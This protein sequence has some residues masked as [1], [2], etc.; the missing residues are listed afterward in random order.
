MLAGRPILLDRIDVH[1]SW[2]S[3]KVL[4]LIGHLPETVE[5]GLIVRDNKGIPTGVTYPGI[6]DYH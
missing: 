3:S 6:I 4:D 5:G 2:V 1:A